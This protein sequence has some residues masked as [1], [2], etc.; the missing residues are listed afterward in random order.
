MAAFA[1]ISASIVAPGLIQAGRQPFMRM[2]SRARR[3]PASAAE[4]FLALCLQAGLIDLER[5]IPG[6]SCG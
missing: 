3:Q 2:I 6:P 5:E 4:D 1:Q